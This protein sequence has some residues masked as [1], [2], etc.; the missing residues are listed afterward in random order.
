MDVTRDPRI[1]AYIR[2][3]HP[4]TTEMVRWSDYRRYAAFLRESPH[5]PPTRIVDLGCA[6]GVQAI[7]FS[8]IPYV[9]IAQELPLGHGPNPHGAVEPIPYFSAPA[10]V[11]SYV[12]THCPDLDFHPRP[13]DCYIANLSIG[14][15]PQAASSEAIAAGLSRFSQGFF[16]G[17]PIIHEALSE[18]FA[19]RRVLWDDVIPM[20]G[21]PNGFRSLA[22]WYA[23]ADPP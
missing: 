12:V 9:G 6:Y 23:H 3:Y 22:V 10:L 15:E 2:Q 5:Q 20:M 19:V 1:V 7:L 18:V 21:Y 16:H 8:P 14:Y 13:G 17:S 11:T 4:V